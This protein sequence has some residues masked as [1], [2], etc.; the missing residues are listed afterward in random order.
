M[1]G[2]AHSERLTG[3]PLVQ[4]WTAGGEKSMD[5]SEEVDNVAAR[6]DQHH[7]PET[8]G[9]MAVCRRCGAQTDGPDGHH[10]VPGKGRV[11]HSQDW[12]DVQSRLRSIDVLKGMLSR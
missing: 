11:K 2:V 8:N 12:L 3:Q 10:H 4:D 1:D 6:L 5:S 9:R 7:S